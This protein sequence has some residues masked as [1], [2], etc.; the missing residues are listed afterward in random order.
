MFG[1]VTAS[2][3]ASAS[4]ERHGPSRSGVEVSDSNLKN[5]S[6]AAQWPWWRVA[7]IPER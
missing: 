2:Q 1:L 4:V 7:G 6:A 3:M 5:L